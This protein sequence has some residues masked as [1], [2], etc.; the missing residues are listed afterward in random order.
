MNQK[1]DIEAILVISLG[2]IVFYFIF[3]ERILLTIP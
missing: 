3:D 1:K 2:L